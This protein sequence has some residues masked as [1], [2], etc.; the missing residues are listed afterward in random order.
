MKSLRM[1]AKFTMFVVAALALLPASALA[2]SST[3]Y[4]KW[5]LKSASPTARVHTGMIRFGLS[6]IPNAAFSVTKVKADTETVERLTANSGGDW[7]TGAT[8]FG[9]VFGP[10][11]PSSTKQYIEV[12]EDSLGGTNR[13]TTRITFKSEVPAGLLGIAIGDLDVDQ[14]VVTAKTA[15]GAVL[16]GNQLR[17]LAAR[18]PFNFCNVK[19]SKPTNCGSD[20]DVPKWLPGRHGGTIKG[21]DSSSDG[22]SGWLRP[23]RPVKSITMTFSALPGSSTHSFRLWLAAKARP[24]FTG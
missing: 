3:A 16:S 21:L 18:V 10:S 1:F 20:T 7:L 9:A 11:G 22:A 5:S 8:Q 12:G 13:T 23:N 19:V 6:G 14:M 17:G 2:A 24:A 4:A 15:S